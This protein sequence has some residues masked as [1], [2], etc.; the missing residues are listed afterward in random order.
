LIVRL[1]EAESKIKDWLEKEEEARSLAI[2]NAQKKLNAY[3]EETA[4]AVKEANDKRR[5]RIDSARAIFLSLML[6]FH[7]GLLTGKMIFH[8][9]KVNGRI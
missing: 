8:Q 5:A 1:E 3:K 2:A 4:A 7:L 9:E 6:L